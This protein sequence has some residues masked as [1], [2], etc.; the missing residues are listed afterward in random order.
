V[1]I[2]KKNEQKNIN[3]NLKLTFISIVTVAS[4]EEFLVVDG[5]SSNFILVSAYNHRLH[6]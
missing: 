6:I 3:N 2:N 4:S 5:F 1:V